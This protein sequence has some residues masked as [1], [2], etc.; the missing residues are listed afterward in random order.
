MRVL[1]IKTSALGDV[2]HAYGIASYLKEVQGVTHLSWLVEGAGADLLEDHPHVD[3]VIQVQTKRWRKNIFA[4]KTREDFA[5]LRRKLRGSDK[6]DLV[7]DLQGNIKSGLLVSLCDAPVKLGFGKESVPERP[8]MWFTNT[9]IDVSKDI[10]VREGY[11]KLVQSYFG[12][13]KLYQPSI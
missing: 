8:N 5:I 7:I 10:P 3:E 1:L 9:H 2:V 11:L 12:D 4:K 6:Y 13:Y